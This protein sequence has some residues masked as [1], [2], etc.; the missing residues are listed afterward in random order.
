M[1]LGFTVGLTC[2]GIVRELIGAGQIFGKQILPI[3]DAAAGQSRICT[4]Y[5]L[6]SCTGSIP[7]TCMTGCTSE[8]NQKQMLQRR[9]KKLQKLKGCG[10]GCASDVM[11]A[12]EKYFLQDNEE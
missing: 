9:A 1:G 10:E 2:I 8:Q 6:Y 12:A 11:D 4:G 3:A 7:C 5:N